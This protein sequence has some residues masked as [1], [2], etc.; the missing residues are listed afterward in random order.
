MSKRGASLVEYSSSDSDDA[1]GDSKSRPKRRSKTATL[2]SSLIVPAPIDNP[3]L[4]QGR[5]RSTPHVDGQWASHVYVSLKLSRRSSLYTLLNEVIHTARCDVPTLNGF[6]VAEK[7]VELH[8]SLSR[9]IFLRAYQ[10]E[11]LK[12][13][14]KG[15][16]DKTAR[17][18]TLSF[19]AIAELTNDE[20][21]RTF[22]AVE[23]GAGHEELVR[24]S[25]G[26]KP[27]LR[28]L[29]QK[30][31]YDSPRYHA[32]IA[33]ALVNGDTAPFPTKTLNERYQA[34]L[35]GKANFFE[36]ERVEVKIG[37]DVFG[38][39]FKGAS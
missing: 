34:A 11:D 32:S 21:T 7:A 18:F 16:A 22:L 28:H 33:W 15:L 30:E 8:V 31:Y 39:R 37:K 2:S 14:V 6:W 3:A 20:K 4:H 27:L 17:A 38:W 19:A 5:V 13:A 1:N 35:A 25:D 12:C 26:L 29:R 10:R 9:P 24:L 36:A 23:V